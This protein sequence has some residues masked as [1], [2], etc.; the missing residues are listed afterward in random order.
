M[1]AR[2]GKREDI[3]TMC[4][5]GGKKKEC[6]KLLTKAKMYWTP[7][8][9]GFNNIDGAIVVNNTLYVLQM[10]VSDGKGKPFDVS[11]LKST[12]IDLS[13]WRGLRTLSFT[14]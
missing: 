11:T 7:L 12:F 5:A 6:P 9:S 1:I 4:W 13:K 10:T 3:E 2:S 8:V 14:L